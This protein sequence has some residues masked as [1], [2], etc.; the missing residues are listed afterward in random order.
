MTADES[1]VAAGNPRVRFELSSGRRAL[2]A[3]DG[4]RLI[5][6][7]A[8]NVESWPFDQEMPRTVLSSPHGVRAVP[9]VPNFSWAEYGLRCG[10]PRILGLL[11][12]RGVPA[13]VMLGA[14]V[15]DAYPE[16][17]RALLRPSL[18]LVGHGVRQRSLQLEQEE[19]RLIVDCLDRIERFSGIRPRGWLS[20]GLQ[21]SFRTP[22]L[23]KQVG[24]DY[25]CDW[26]LDDLPCWIDTSAGRLVAV[27]YTLELN[28]SVIY[29][30]ERQHSAALYERVRD[31]IRTL[32]G[33]LALGPRTIT[34]A[35]HPH[36]IGVPHRIGYLAKALDALAEL[37]QTVFVTGARIADWFIAAERSDPR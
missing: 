15:I 16:A 37:E 25:V 18:E 23:L 4:K 1:Q 28:D 31:T 5:V 30:V 22:D 34:L 32:L 36:L 27:P 33:E 14:E 24:V 21:E 11:D 7:V 26:T 10:L 8:L 20:P 17:A 13:S 3:L 9:D 2:P 12:R 19:S 6:H 29:A 35:L